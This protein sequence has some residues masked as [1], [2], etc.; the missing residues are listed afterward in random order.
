MDLSVDAKGDR[1]DST[2]QFH[3]VS[4]SH[5]MRMQNGR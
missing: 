2:V 1:I 3:N 5:V 4:I